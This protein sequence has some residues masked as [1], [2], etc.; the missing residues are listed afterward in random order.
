MR[1]DCEKSIFKREI[2]K[3]FFVKLQKLLCNSKK[4]RQ[5][6]FFGWWMI[7]TKISLIALITPK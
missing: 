4:Q 3:T 5:K 1:I 7:L 6:Y 2:S